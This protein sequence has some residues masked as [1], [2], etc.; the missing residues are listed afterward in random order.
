M[1]QYYQN[2]NV[3]IESNACRKSSIFFK[4][5]PARLIFIFKNMKKSNLSNKKI[6]VTNKNQTNKLIPLSRLTAQEKYN[7]LTIRMHILSFKYFLVYCDF[8]FNK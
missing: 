2:F 1:L 4:N 6:A 7:L 5:Q 3:N 8:Y